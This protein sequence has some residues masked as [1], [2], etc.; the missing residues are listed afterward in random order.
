MRFQPGAVHFSRLL[1][2]YVV[3]LWHYVVV[4]LLFIFYSWLIVAFFI[5][6]RKGWRSQTQPSNATQP[7]MCRRLTCWGQRSNKFC[8]CHHE[9]S[10]SLRP[11]QSASRS[12]LYYYDIIDVAVLSFKCGHGRVSTCFNKSV[13]KVCEKCVES[14]WNC[15]ESVWKVCEKKCVESVRKVCGKCVESVWKVCGKCV[16]NTSSEIL[17]YFSEGSTWA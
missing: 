3:A 11:G 8:L 9:A 7:K 15:V 13:W 6:K 14:V 10:N 12:T 5:G 2:Y 4:L 16:N 17:K 1:S